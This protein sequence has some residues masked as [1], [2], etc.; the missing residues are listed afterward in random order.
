M[1]AKLARLAS[2]RGMAYLLLGAGTLATVA[3]NYAHAHSNPGAKALSAVVPVLLFIAFH[4][5]AKDGRW[6]IR[7]ST[8]AVALLCFSISYDHIS[9]LAKSYG[10]KG[11]SPVLYPLAI[12]GAMIVATFVLSRPARTAGLSA[13]LTAKAVREPVRP[14]PA[15][16]SEAPK[17]V[18][19]AVPEGSPR[20]NGFVRP[21]PPVRPKREDSP[22]DTLSRD[23]E[24]RLNAARKIAEELGDRLSRGA[25]VK[26]LKEQ[27][28]KISTNEAAALTRQLKAVRS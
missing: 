8:G 14:K 22:A 12:D 21:M 19:S 13:V 28:Y 25:L 17:P 5:A 24:A 10:E 7:V 18:L 9:A 2:D 27:G 11:L 16:L 26:A 15:V 4:V 3:A 6:W 1:R 23:S 20:T